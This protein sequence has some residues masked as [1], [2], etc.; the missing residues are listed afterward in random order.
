MK[1][2]DARDA[3]I[4]GRGGDELFGEGGVGAVVS[5]SVSVHVNVHVHVHVYVYVRVLVYVDV[6]VDVD[7]VADAVDHDNPPTPGATRSHLLSSPTLCTAPS[8]FRSTRPSA[9]RAKRPAS[10]AC[11]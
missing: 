2:R 3:N 4:N 11:T 8:L 10:P 1:R 6:Y 9:C 7:A 5:D